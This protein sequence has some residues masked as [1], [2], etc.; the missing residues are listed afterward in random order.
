MDTLYTS[1]D[2]GLSNKASY[3]KAEDAPK[4]RF[5]FVNTCKEDPAS[6]KTSQQQARK[7]LMLEYYRHKRAQ[8]IAKFE[9]GRTAALQTNAQ[10]T[11]TIPGPIVLPRAKPGD[12]GDA[13]GQ[14]DS[15]VQESHKSPG[16][17][18]A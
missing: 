1:D 4:A 16:P 18:A 3:S 10:T 13:R 12:S 8:D 9:S 17:F 2:A 11:C 15:D 6:V 5:T 14:L 7:H